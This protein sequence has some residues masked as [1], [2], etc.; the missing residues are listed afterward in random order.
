[1][2]GGRPRSSQAGAF[3]TSRTFP[4]KRDRPSAL[5][6]PLSRAEEGLLPEGRIQPSRVALVGVSTL[7]WSAGA[8]DFRSFG[9]TAVHVARIGALGASNAA[10]GDHVGRDGRCVNEW[11]AEM[12]GCVPT[13]QGYRA[14]HFLAIPLR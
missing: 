9:L 2:R 5:P 14:V 6:A 4:P 13:V 11:L 1:M 3:P 7:A 12:E 8:Q 10:V